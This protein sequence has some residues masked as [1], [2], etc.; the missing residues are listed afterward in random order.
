MVGGVSRE[1]ENRKIKKSNE[2]DDITE[3]SLLQLTVSTV[4]ILACFVVSKS[5]RRPQ[6]VGLFSFN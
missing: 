5:L 1:K 4:H 6:L 2:V 3:R